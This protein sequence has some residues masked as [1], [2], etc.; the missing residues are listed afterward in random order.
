MLCDNVVLPPPPPG[1]SMKR[2]KTSFDTEIL[3]WHTQKYWIQHDWFAPYN[4][5]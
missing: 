1:V 2:N 4:K 5:F 3:T